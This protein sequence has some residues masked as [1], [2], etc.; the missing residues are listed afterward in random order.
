MKPYKK[1]AKIEVL[2]NEL[3]TRAKKDSKNRGFS[4]Y[5]KEVVESYKQLES[6]KKEVLKSKSSDDIKRNLNKF[7][8]HGLGI[9]DSTNRA[10]KAIYG[11]GKIE[12][13]KTL[14]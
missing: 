4:G 3:G 12:L 2:A 7:C 1:I 5:L 9:A 13:K 10:L 6:Y 11:K 14:R 8:F